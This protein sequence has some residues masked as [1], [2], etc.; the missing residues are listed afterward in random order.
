MNIRDAPKYSF[1]Y[2]QKEAFM[3]CHIYRDNLLK[4]PLKL[5]KNELYWPLPTKNH[6]QK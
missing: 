3:A 5:E 1:T 4:P 6:V 2:K